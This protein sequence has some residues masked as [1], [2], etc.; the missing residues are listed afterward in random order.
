[1]VREK[2]LSDEEIRER[3]FIKRLEN[4]AN[5]EFPKGSC[6]SCGGIIIIYPIN[7]QKDVRIILSMIPTQRYELSIDNSDSRKF[8]LSLGKAYERDPTIRDCMRNEG[9]SEFIVKKEY[10]E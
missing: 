5:I 8:A 10:Q 4:I 3:N 2:G 9:V 7:D 1:M 6:E